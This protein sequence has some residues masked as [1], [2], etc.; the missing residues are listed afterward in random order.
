MSLSDSER[1][2]QWEIVHEYLREGYRAWLARDGASAKAVEERMGLSV[3]DGMDYRRHLV[4]LGLIA[5]AETS[6]DPDF[7]LLPPGTAFMDGSPTLERLLALSAEAVKQAAPT[8][9]AANSV[10]RRWRNLVIEWGIKRG[11]DYAW[12][13]RLS[14]WEGLIRAGEA[15]RVPP[16][17]PGN[18]T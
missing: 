18:I 9:T 1:P 4:Q 15:W 16:L 3:Q 6:D 12:D 7:R 5:L 14:M 13:N 8:P 11:F 2:T 17:P 10:M